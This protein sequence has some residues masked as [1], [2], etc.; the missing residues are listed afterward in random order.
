[1]ILDSLENWSLYSDAPAWK[2]A[3]AFLTGL[4][5]TV[6]PGEYE[7]S[8][9]DVYAVVFETPTKALLDATI[10]AHRNYADI[11]LPLSGPEVHARF[12]LT[13]LEEKTP[14]DGER[15]ALTFHAPDRFGALFTLK[16]G[17][18][19]LYLPQDAHLTQGKADPRPGVLR[20]AVV[21]L[22]AELLRP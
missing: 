1:M 16:P 20:K 9:R 22:K 7:L 4:E 18:F 10:E 11:H 14:Y 5:P 15:D 21:K 3:F 8:G 19:A 12:E 17:Q 6:E 2:L 13:E